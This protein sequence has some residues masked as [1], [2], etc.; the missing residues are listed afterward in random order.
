MSSDLASAWYATLTDAG[1][2]GLIFGIE[3]HWD[4]RME[5]DEKGVGACKK[6]F[7]ARNK[8]GEGGCMLCVDVLS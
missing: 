4:F 7:N 8:T 5:Q 1:W 2:E 6:L 3:K